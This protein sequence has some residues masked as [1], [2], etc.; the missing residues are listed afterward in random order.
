MGVARDHVHEAP[1]ASP[2]GEGGLAVRACGTLTH[3]AAGGA[4][5]VARP[6]D[7]A[8]RERHFGA[9]GGGPC[10]CRAG[11]CARLSPPA[12]ALSPIP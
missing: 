10:A 5:A 7:R 3:E 8:P 12:A 4:L 2:P 9:E 6:R 1:S 11:A